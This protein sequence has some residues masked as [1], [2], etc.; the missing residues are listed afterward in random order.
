MAVK[1]E[2]IKALEAEYQTMA[3]IATHFAQEMVAQLKELLGQY[4]M[5]LGGSIEWQVRT[6]TSISEEIERGPGNLSTLKDLSDLIRIRLVLLFRRDIEPS[7]DVLS[8]NFRIISREHLVDEQEQN[9]FGYSSTRFVVAVPDSWVSLP[10][11]RSM[12][13]LKAEIQVR[14]LAQHLWAC[15]S[16]RLQYT[17][18]KAVPSP[19]RRTISRVSSLLET[20]DLEFERVIQ[21]KEQYVGSISLEKGVKEPLN[22][23]SLATVLDSMLPKNNKDSREPEGYSDLLD[24][25][26][27]FEITQTSTLKQLIKRHLD[28]IIEL[29]KKRVRLEMESTQFLEECRDRIRNRVYYT[30]SGL[31]RI[32]LALEFGKRWERYIAN[33][34]AKSVT[35]DL[36]DDDTLLNDHDIEDD[37]LVISSTNGNGNGRHRQIGVEATAD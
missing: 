23:N 15:A 26:L 28:E 14:T 17:K 30:H 37:E 6:W 5:D 33:R 9:E 29:D 11:L 35:I 2:Q 24:D 4:E 31:V 21:E 32:A 8:A 25:L 1:R 19:I 22:V 12:K 13:G 27:H 7:C 3:P 10:T 18:M 36:E 34:R 20:V 16:S